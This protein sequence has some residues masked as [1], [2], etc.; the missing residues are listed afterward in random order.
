MSR[1][2]DKARSYEGAMVRWHQF[3]RVILA[4]RSSS[5]GSHHAYAAL[6]RLP[7]Q[8]RPSSPHATTA[9]TNARLPP[10]QRRP[11]QKPRPAALAE[12]PRVAR[13]ASFPGWR[14]ASFYARACT[15]PLSLSTSH[16]HACTHPLVTQTIVSSAPVLATAS[17]SVESSDRAS[18][19]RCRP[20]FAMP[21]TPT[22]RRAKPALTSGQIY[23]PVW[24]C[25]Y[26][27][28]VK[29]LQQAYAQICQACLQKD[30]E[31]RKRVVKA[32]TAMRLGGKE[33]Q[34]HCCEAMDGFDQTVNV[35]KRPVFQVCTTKMNL[36][37][38]ADLEDYVCRLDKIS[39]AD[40]EDFCPA[41]AKAVKTMKKAEK[42]LL[43]YMSDV[44]VS[45]RLLRHIIDLKRHFKR[46]GK[47]KVVLKYFQVGTVVE[48]ASE[49]YSSR[50]K[51]RERK[52]TLVDELLS[53]QSLKS[54]RVQPS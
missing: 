20:R 45:T 40:V 27:H 14:D 36:S 37:D 5:H 13:A 52:A 32:E 6:N 38:E 47:F 42:L 24:C 15:M 53:D 51:N 26:D 41:L 9:E 35:K 16:A 18:G 1:A 19:R 34:I 4:L 2:E 22:R 44:P 31:I 54:Y 48:P 46:V 39:D 12:I 17:T 7:S 30:E 50:L 28:L 43:I 8:R 11:F 33:L 10:H 29:M 25:A 3:C 49:F 21:P 23:L